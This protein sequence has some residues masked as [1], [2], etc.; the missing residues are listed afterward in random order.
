VSA[1]ASRFAWRA[2]CAALACFGAAC[3]GP[4]GPFPGGHLDGHVAPALPASWPSCRVLELETDP[5]VPRSVNMHFVSEGPHLWV[6]TVLGGSDWAHD[7]I[8]DPNVRV[9]LGNEV[10]EVKAVHVTDRNEIL[11][12]AELYRE[13][14][15]FTPNVASGKAWVFELEP[16]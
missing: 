9:R 16:R 2:A 5:G 10:Y 4:V 3:F 15:V 6:A 11:H 1:V 8:S 12:V 13:K 7:A 14:Y